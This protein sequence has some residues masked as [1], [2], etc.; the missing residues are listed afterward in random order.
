MMQVYVF[1]MY[2]PSGESFIEQIDIDECIKKH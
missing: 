2:G 1:V